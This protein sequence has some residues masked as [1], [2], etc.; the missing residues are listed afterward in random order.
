MITGDTRWAREGGDETHAHE[1][2]VTRQH[3]VSTHTEAGD[4]PLAR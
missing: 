4:L 1:L 2:A 3:F